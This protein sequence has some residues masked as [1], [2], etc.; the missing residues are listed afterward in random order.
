VADRLV[1]LENLVA[2]VDERQRC[3]DLYAQSLT[4]AEIDLW[5]AY[6]AVLEYRLSHRVWPL[7]C[8][9]CL[10]PVHRKGRGRFPQVCSSACR[11]AL[12]RW[13]AF[14]RVGFQ[15]GWGPTAQAPALRDPFDVTISTSG[16]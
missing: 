12:A 11:T 16:S 13:R 4:T 8:V 9:W 1:D 15:L 7:V 10:R 6:N 2:D 3:V 14:A 5:F